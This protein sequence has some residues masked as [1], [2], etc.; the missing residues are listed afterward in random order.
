MEE[1]LAAIKAMNCEQARDSDWQVQA[2]VIAVR[3]SAKQDLN[4]VAR[5]YSRYVL[6][7]SGG[8]NQRKETKI[9]NLWLRSLPMR[10]C[11]I[12]CRI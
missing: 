5:Y 1:K 11:H 9:E 7:P 6:P 4:V 8:F 3:I 10:T 12:I 2:D